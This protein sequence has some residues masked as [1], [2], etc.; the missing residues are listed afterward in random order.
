MALSAGIRLGAYEI[1]APLGKGGMGEVYRAYDT[2][3]GREVAIKVLPEH[4]T[5]N[6]DALKRFEREARAL[7][8]LSHPNILTIFDVG[9]HGDISYVVTE[10]LE[11]QT[12][13]RRLDGSSLPWKKALAIVIPIAEG[14]SAAQSK[15]VIHRDLKPEN[16]FLT[17]EERVKIL[18]FGLARQTHTKVPDNITSA[19]TASG[20]LSEAGILTGTLPYMS[21][22]QVRGE[23]LD[24]RNDIF[25]FGCMLYEMLKG[26]RPFSRSTTAETLAAILKEEPPDLIHAGK[27][28][29]SELDHIVMRCLEK[30]KERRFQSAHDLAFAL[31][32][33]Q[34]V[35]TPIAKQTK[36]PTRLPI[37]G[38]LFAIG[39][40]ALGLA[41]N[42]GG[43]RERL[44]GSPK[45]M[46]KSIAVLPLE[47]LPRDPKEEY[48]A[49]G[50]TEALITDLAKIG[51]LKVI[52]RTSVMQYKQTKKPIREIAQ[53][54]NVDALIEGSVL[55]AGDQVRITA[56]LIDAAT[57]EHI[58]A[59]SYERET[60]NILAL[61]REVASAIAR[62]IKV[63][64]TPQEQDRLGGSRTV[65]PEAYEAYLKGQFYRAKGTEEGYNASIDYFQRAIELDPDYPASYAGLAIAY[66]ALGN[67]GFRPPMDVYPKS[68]EIARKALEKDPN[69]GETHAVLGYIKANYDWDWPG[70]E[71]EYKRAI[72][73]NPNFALAYDFYSYFLGV[74]NRIDEALAVRKKAL[75]LDPVSLAFN[76]NM[77][78]TLRIA[79]RLDQAVTHLRKT[80]QLDSNFPRAHV[81]LGQCYE[82]K[83]NYPAAIDEFQKA[84][85]FSNN[86]PYVLAALGHA[87]ARAGRKED[88]LQILNELTDLSKR[89]YVS[90][91][92]IA[93][94]Y[95]G[96]EDKDETFSWLEKAYKERA[97]WLILLNVDQLWDPMRNDGRFKD[98][99]HR[100]N[101]QGDN[102]GT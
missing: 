38:A 18:D 19:P 22:E 26:E 11:G 52:S 90:P 27:E 25:S 58:W 84:K 1:V 51:S 42:V 75:E 74:Q 2:R 72:E 34:K 64:L 78:W 89:R 99:L 3:L 32:E 33:I 68:K 36:R 5:K 16:V 7:A 31:Q 81:W 69:L 23:T 60:S 83:R 49:D 43:F 37:F 53:E 20:L 12:L 73:L 65:Q 30:N 6:P 15:G 50:M 48:F 91:Y 35:P 85:I 28:I 92:D 98:L 17:S 80:L 46:I 70:A 88:A 86:S 96:L 71:T 41:L 45:R 67:F 97:T 10:L 102:D 101:F 61:Q 9:A 4:L 40:L 59:E 47:N 93:L 95:A 87:Y 8:A 66:V 54:L 94:V 57:D 13:R 63:K 14:L 100:M 29:P 56:Q 76:T 79:G 39:L 82:V 62:Q 55:R 77:G 24:A 21:P 44:F